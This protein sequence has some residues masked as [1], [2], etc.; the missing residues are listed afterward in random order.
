MINLTLAISFAF[1]LAGLAVHVGMW[2]T[3]RA[4]VASLILMGQ[5]VPVGFGL[6]LWL[7]LSH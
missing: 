7:S 2:E 4:R 1:F 6:V 5:V 3:K